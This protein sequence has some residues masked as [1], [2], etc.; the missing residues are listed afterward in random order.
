MSSLG[1]ESFR[2]ILF[3]KPMGVLTRFTDDRGRPTLS[4][5]IDVP[6]VY[7]IGRLDQNSEGLLLL[8]DRGSLVE[9]L[10][11]PGGKTKTYLVCVEGQPSQDQLA[12]LRRGPTL[13][14]GP[15]LPVG[16]TLLE[17][18]PEWLW[19]RDPPIRF[20]K[21]VPVS[22]LELVLSE[23]RNRQVRRMTAAVGLPTLR[24]VR[25]AVGPLTLPTDLS[26]GHWRE[27][28]VS[29]KAEILRIAKP[30]TRPPKTRRRRKGAKNRRK[31]KK[32]NSD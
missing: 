24:L 28:S 10:L 25:S 2:F 5:Y 31:T 15:S 21:T 4:D 7:P 6:D 13:K 3:N 8:T 1:R 27:A 19:E 23:G 20:R 22:W 30:L 17:A 14:D 29:E 9:P 18:E 16:V 32:R 26:P 12:A 11:R